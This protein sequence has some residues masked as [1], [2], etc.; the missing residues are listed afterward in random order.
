MTIGSFQPPL[1]SFSVAMASGVEQRIG[2]LIRVNGQ[3]WAFSD[4]A[5]LSMDP[6]KANAFQLDPSLLLESTNSET[7]R[8]HY[9][10]QGEPFAA[11][12]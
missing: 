11:R 8:K 10:Y 2:Y 12:Q 6:E 5:E 9:V 1:V 7:G 3:P 4:A